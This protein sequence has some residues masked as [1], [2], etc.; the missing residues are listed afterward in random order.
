MLASNFLYDFN[1]VSVF[2][3]VV[4]VLFVLS[5]I[6]FSLGAFIRKRWP[7]KTS[8]PSD[9]V[10]T[11]ILGLVSLF[12]GFTFSM[13]IDRYDGR[14][15]LVVKEANAIGTAYL[16]TQ[17]IDEHHGEVA[18]EL[19]KKYVDA[20]LEFFDA[21]ADAQAIERAEEKTR[22][23]QTL[24]W[25]EAVESTRLRAGIP[26]GQ[27]TSALNDVIDLQT[28]RAAALV[29]RVPAIVYWMILVVAGIGLGGLEFGK[30]IQN[31]PRLWSMSLLIL[32]FASAITLIQDLDRPRTGTITVSQESMKALKKSMI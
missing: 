1:L 30:A 21:G 12:L 28:E 2:I 31:K 9:F 16:R 7:D 10:I 3:S 32:L 23:V 20:R 4:I 29:N 8:G 11:T 6:G 18:R 27:F 15:E 14:K 26:E 19:F 13:A 24:L 25:H 5:Q 17:M 22:S